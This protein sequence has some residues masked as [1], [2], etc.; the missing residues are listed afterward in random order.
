MREGERW[1]FM[2]LDYLSFSELKRVRETSRFEK[3]ELIFLADT[4]EVTLQYTFA[5][6]NVKII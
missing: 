1:V 2:V 6:F 4:I 3:L 5:F